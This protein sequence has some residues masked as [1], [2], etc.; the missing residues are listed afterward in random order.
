MSIKKTGAR[1][2]SRQKIFKGEPVPFRCR[3][4][5]QLYEKLR[6]RAIKKPEFAQFGVTPPARGGISA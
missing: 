6:A 3:L 4:E 2:T 1:K 5:P